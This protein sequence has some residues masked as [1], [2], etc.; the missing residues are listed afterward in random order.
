M[1]E[2]V[3]LVNFLLQ[4]RHKVFLHS[5]TGTTLAPRKGREPPRGVKY[6]ICCFQRHSIASKLA[7]SNI[8]PS[9]KTSLVVKCVS[10][11]EKKVR[12]SSIMRVILAQRPC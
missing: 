10:E 12:F 11:Q 6:S 1:M 3:Q 2:G 8:T 7:I 9:V 5:T 4:N